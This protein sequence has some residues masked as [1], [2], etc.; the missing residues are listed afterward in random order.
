MRELEYIEEPKCVVVGVHWS[1]RVCTLVCIRE[2]VGELGFIEDPEWVWLGVLEREFFYVLNC[3]SV[4]IVFP[5]CICQ[6]L[7]WVSFVCSSFRPSPLQCDLLPACLW[8]I[9]TLRWFRGYGWSR[10]QTSDITQQATPISI[11]SRRTQCFTSTN[12]AYSS[13]L[14]SGL[15]ALHRSIHLF[16]QPLNLFIWGCVDWSLSWEYRHQVGT[17]YGLA[18]TPQGTHIHRHTLR[19]QFRSSI[20]L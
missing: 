15:L 10:G 12:T 9:I 16:S 19:G 1:T 6:W 14:M 13:S 18:P 8:K 11:D 17:N 2:P 4:W 3:V 20:N 7:E 5:L